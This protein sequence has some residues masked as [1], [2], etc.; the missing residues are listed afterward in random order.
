[1]VPGRYGSWSSKLRVY[2]LNSKRGTWA[3]HGSLY[4]QNPLLVKYFLQQEKPLK[5]L[6]TAHETWSKGAGGVDDISLKPPLVSWILV[7]PYKF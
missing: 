3:W 6:Q 5:S 2:I 4:S 1:M 7:V